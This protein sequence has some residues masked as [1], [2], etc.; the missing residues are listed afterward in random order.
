MDHLLQLSEG[1]HLSDII[2]LIGDW[3]ATML[4]FGPTGGHNAAD[5]ILPPQHGN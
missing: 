4:T 1:V 5:A 3:L 2:R